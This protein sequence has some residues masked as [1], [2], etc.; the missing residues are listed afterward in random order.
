MRLYSVYDV[1]VKAYGLPFAA[2]TNSEAIRGFQKEANSENSALFQSAGD[3]TL[4]CIA[5][6]DDETGVITPLS[7]F[8]NLGTALQY[9]STD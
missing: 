5:E 7:G 8:E 4:F 1:A 9:K 3:Y 2:R 6:Y